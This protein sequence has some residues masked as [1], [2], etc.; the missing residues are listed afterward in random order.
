MNFKKWWKKSDLWK[1]CSLITVTLYLIVLLTALVLHLLYLKYPCPEQ[2][3]ICVPY[4][5]YIIF[6][7]TFP[8]FLLFDP[9]NYDNVV[10][11]I[12]LGFVLYLLLG[13]LIGFI[14]GKIIEKTKC[15][16]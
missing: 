10:L 4:S 3:S 15:K 11:L 6:F 14:I 16:K 7:A 8:L 1:K 5:M 9:I 2:Y 13:T 12:I